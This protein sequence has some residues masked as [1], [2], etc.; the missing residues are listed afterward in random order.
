VYLT[1][2][3]VIICGSL[4]FKTTAG[5]KIRAVGENPRAADVL[6][7]NVYRIRYLCVIFGGIMAGL[8][9]AYLSLEMGFFREYMVA[10][11]GWIAIAIV[12]FSNWSPYRALGGALLFGIVDGFQMRLGALGYFTMEYQFLRMLPYIAVIVSLVAISRRAGAP[13]ALCVPFKRGEA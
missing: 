2:I 8:A 10:G 4:L 7:T 11:R 1:F 6:G 12:I 13:A 3:L 5:L 9:G